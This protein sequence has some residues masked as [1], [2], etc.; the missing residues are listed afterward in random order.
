MS[1]PSP[2][3][4]PADLPAHRLT[5][6]RAELDR[7]DDALHDG[8]M[9]RAELAAQVGAL[10]AKGSVPL[11]PGREASIMR[12]LLARNHGALDPSTLVRVWRE[13]LA[14]SKEQQHPMTV[15]VGDEALLAPALEHFGA[16]TPVRVAREPGAALDELRRGEATVAVMPWP[17][18]GW[19]TALLD[20][21]A[22]TV[23]VVARLPFWARRS[24]SRSCVVLTAAMP[25]PSGDD[26]SLIAGALPPDGEQACAA[27]LAASGFE[28]G[29]ITCTP[30]FALAD[31][32]GFVAADDG[33]LAPDAIVLG[34]YAVPIGDT[35]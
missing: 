12:R 4:A 5:A 7:V 28:V 29:D 17:G 25:D 27:A 19:W 35:V 20:G 18:E 22:R 2:Q 13:V 31:V 8:L 3:A 21:K 30:R 26:R 33:R 1:N 24:A 16:L 15:A 11:R 32:A 9:R 34:A 6:L 14:G 23:H 10:G